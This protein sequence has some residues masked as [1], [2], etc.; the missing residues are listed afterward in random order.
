MKHLFR[1]LWD[2][3]NDLVLL[4]K[5]RLV[6][7]NIFE[8]IMVKTFQIWWR[9]QCIDLRRLENLKEDKL[10][11]KCVQTHHNQTAENQ[12][13]KKK[14]LNAATEKQDSVTYRRT[15]IQ[16]TTDF[17]F[18]I[19][20]VRRYRTALKVLKSKK[21]RVCLKIRDSFRTSTRFIQVTN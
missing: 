13:Q 8:E 19:T 21:K 1:D 11:K 6:P 15:E 10:K 5:K 9:Y 20:R 14:I 4:Q 16:M 3:I 7:K 12:R 18:E 17:S 2:N